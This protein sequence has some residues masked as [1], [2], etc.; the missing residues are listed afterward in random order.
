MNRCL[1]NTNPSP[2]LAHSPQDTL[3][4]ELEKIHGAV[5]QHIRVAILKFNEEG[6]LCSCKDPV[7]TVKGGEGPEEEAPALSP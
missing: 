7:E 6:R 3:L 2:A 5:N 4:R 1:V